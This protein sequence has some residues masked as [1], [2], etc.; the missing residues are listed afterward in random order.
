MAAELARR[1]SG[2]WRGGAA[3]IRHAFPR[4]STI[5]NVRVRAELGEG[6]RMQSC[7]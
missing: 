1:S 7:S 2:H 3:A 4:N 5:V 6:Y